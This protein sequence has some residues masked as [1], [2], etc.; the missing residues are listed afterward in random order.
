MVWK[1]RTQKMSVSRNRLAHE[2]KDAVM[3]IVMMSIHLFDLHH[4]ILGCC[5]RVISAC[6]KSVS[7]MNLSFYI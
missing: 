6:E 5:D 3:K 1:K 2:S 7:G 4:E